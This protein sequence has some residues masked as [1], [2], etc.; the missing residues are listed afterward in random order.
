VDVDAACAAA[1]LPAG[2]LLTLVENA[3]E[4]GITPTLQGGHVQVQARWHAGVLALEVRDNGAGLAEPL[5]EGLGLANC[6]E[7]LQHRYGPRATLQLLPLQPGACARVEVRS[8]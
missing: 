2:I 3:V 6:R 5:V 8:A 7:R 4:H 1:L